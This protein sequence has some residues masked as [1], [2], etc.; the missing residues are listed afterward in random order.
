MAAGEVFNDP[1]EALGVGADVGVKVAGADEFE[2]RLEAET[3][4]PEVAIP[5]AVAGDDGGVGLQGQASETLGGA[6]GDTEEIYEDT[7]AGQGVEVEEDANGAAGAEDSEKSADG[8]G[9]VYRD[10][11]GK[12]TIAIDE[13]IDTGIVERA[14]EEVQRKAEESLRGRAEL[15]GAHVSG[16]IENALAAMVGGGEVFETVG[17]D[18]A[19]DGS[20]VE[21]VEVNQLGGH[22]AEMAGEVAE[23]AATAGVGPVGEGDA[24]VDETGAAKRRTESVGEARDKRAEGAGGGAGEEFEEFQGEPGEGEFEAAF[25]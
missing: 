25:H 7:F 24:E 18:D 2:R 5:V 6:G 14:D 13:G 3:V 1:S 20:A 4:F 19:V 10:V 21:V 9:F 15:P 22:P 8:V 17:N 23:E 12:T 11:A 16:E